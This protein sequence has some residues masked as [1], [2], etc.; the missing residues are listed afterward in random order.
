M[1]E[2]DIPLFNQSK[3]NF[4]MCAQNTIAGV[5]IVAVLNIFVAPHPTEMYFSA[6]DAQNVPNITM[7]SDRLSVCLQ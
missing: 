7:F 4:F 1:E 3:F 2:G 5:S 6:V